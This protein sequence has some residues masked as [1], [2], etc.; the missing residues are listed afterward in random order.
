MGDRSSDLGNSLGDKSTCEPNQCSCKLLEFA[1]YFN[2]C[3]V[4]LLGSC[5]GS[6]DTFFPHCGR[7]CSTLDY[8]FVPVCL[9]KYVMLKVLICVMKTHLITS[10]LWLN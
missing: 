9:M 3:P 1:D 5:S 10:L 8:I 2:L 7:Y 6:T 4:N